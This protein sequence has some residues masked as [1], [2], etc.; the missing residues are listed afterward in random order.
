MRT[1]CN[2]LTGSSPWVTC[3]F[4]HSSERRKWMDSVKSTS[5]QEECDKCSL[6]WFIYPPPPTSIYQPRT[7]TLPPTHV[8]ASLKTVCSEESWPQGEKA[9]V[10][11]AWV[12]ICEQGQEG[13]WQAHQLDIAGIQAVGQGRLSRVPPEKWACRGTSVRFQPWLGMKCPVGLAG[14][15]GELKRPTQ[16]HGKELL[17]MR[18]NYSIV[19]QQPW[20]WLSFPKT[21]RNIPKDAL[22][23]NDSMQRAG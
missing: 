20:G 8:Q 13:I 4:I 1:C 23:C 2:L 15:A 14:A 21:G 9:C 18:A 6:F 7:S 16:Q 11:W 12:T 17:R 10:I 19:T 22:L 5:F 3:W